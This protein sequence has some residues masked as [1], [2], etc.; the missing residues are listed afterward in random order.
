MAPLDWHA[1][2]VAAT[3]KHMGSR[4]AL[5][6]ATAACGVVLLEPGVAPAH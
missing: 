3:E 1:A 6:A 4:N 5:L 2:P